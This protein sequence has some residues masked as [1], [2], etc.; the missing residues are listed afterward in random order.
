MVPNGGLLPWDNTTSNCRT[1]AT[2]INPYQPVTP[3]STITYLWGVPSEAGPVG[4]NATI[5]SRLWLYGS[6]VDPKLHDNAGLVGPIIVT[7][8]GVAMEEDGRPSDVDRELVV[9]FQVVN[10]GSSAML[11]YNSPA[12]T[13]GVPYTNMAVNG[14]VWCNMPRDHLTL[15]VGERVRW[16]LASVGSNDSLHNYH[17][18]GHTV[19]VNGHHMDEFTGIPGATYSADMKLDEP[20]IWMLHCHVDLHMDGGMVTLYTVQGDPA[21]FPAGGT[22]RVYYVAAEEAEWSYTGADSLEMCGHTPKSSMGD[23]DASNFVEG[24]LAAGVKTRLGPKLIKTLYME[25]TDDTF[26]VKKI[27]P[28]DDSYLGFVGPILRASV[29]DTIKV[30]LLNRASINISMHPHGLRYSKANEGA[31]YRDGTAANQKL[32]DAVQPNQA[33]TYLWQVPPRSGPGPRDPSSVVWMYHSHLNETAET[34]AGLVGAIIVTSPAKAFNSVSDPRPIDVDREVITFFSVTDEI[35]SSN[36]MDN[37]RTRLGDGG[38]LAADADTVDELRSDPGFQKHMLKHSINGFLFCSMPKLTFVQGD[39]VRMYAMALGSLRDMHTPNM[40]G[41]RFDY[42]EQHLDS[43]QMSPGSMI[44]ADVIMTSPG[45]G[46]G[47]AAA[48]GIGWGGMGWGGVGSGGLVNTTRPSGVTRKYYIQAEA[49]EWDYAPSGYKAYSDASFTVATRRP[50]ITVGDILEIHL[51][52][53]LTDLPDYPVNIQMGGGLGELLGEDMCPKVAAGETCVYRWMIPASAGPGTAD[54]STTVYGYTSTVDVVSAPSAGLVG[55]LVVAAPGVLQ[56]SKLQPGAVV[57]AGVDLMIPLHWQ[58]MDEEMS[59]YWDMNKQIA[60]VNETAINNE[61]LIATY[62]EG[63]LK[64]AINGFLYCNLP[65]LNIPTGSTVRWLLV[66]YGSESDFHA[67][68]FMGQATKVDMAGFSTLASLMPS[69]ARVADMLAVAKGT[70]L[71]SCA[72]EDYYLL[73]EFTVA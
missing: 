30:V 42:E 18:H 5:S 1:S 47:A 27:R 67:P 32:D 25:Y 19:E 20:G 45:G 60:G 44:T 59:P 34:Y 68:Y 23:M 33:Y 28:L 35:A 36:F 9:L 37:L 55:A 49:V 40:G 6:S 64:H 65:G 39:K 54:F 15:A 41:P 57:P 71:L 69:V 62:H 38:A 26:T 50:R 72:V 3:G 22:E 48:A 17:W 46:G 58:M 52:N 56:P 70:W 43:V 29:G 21:P 11:P 8:P 12:L 4:P 14:Y 2:A 73:A 16:H 53:N 31:M 51:R 13:S 61:A 63:N 66:T 10:E 7:G 24:P